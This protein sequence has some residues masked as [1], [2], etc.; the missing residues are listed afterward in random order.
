M[1]TKSECTPASIASTTADFHFVS[2]CVTM[3]FFSVLPP[4]STEDVLSRKKLFSD[5]LQL[6]KQGSAWLFFSFSSTTSTF[7]SFPLWLVLVCT[8]GG[9]LCLLLLFS[10]RSRECS[11]TWQSASIRLASLGVFLSVCL[12]Y[13]SKSISC[14]CCSIISNCSQK[15]RAHFVLFVRYFVQVCFSCL[16]SWW[17]HLH[18]VK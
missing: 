12:W 8:S 10:H 16:L 4:L 9:M 3:Y 7:H 13:A 17:A 15:R 6:G 11:V 1:H 14:L 18:T 2:H 5:H